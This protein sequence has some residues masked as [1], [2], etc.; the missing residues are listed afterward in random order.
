M[1]VMLLLPLPP[2]VSAAMTGLQGASPQDLDLL[3]A[4]AA[5]ADQDSNVLLQRHQSSGSALDGDGVW[6]PEVALYSSMAILVFGL[7]MCLIIA[8]LLRSRRAAGDIL[9]TLC[10]PLIVV[11]AVFLVVAGYSERQIAPVIGLLGTI[12]G[13]LLGK[14]PET[15]HTSGPGRTASSP[16]GA[17]QAKES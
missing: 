2:T 1:Q 17:E 14:S 16:L 13:Y 4:D 5:A 9:R 12:A 3:R 6:T 10:V 7:I 15:E 8:Y 11:S